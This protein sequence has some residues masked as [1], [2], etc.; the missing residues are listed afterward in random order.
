MNRDVTV[1]KYN[2]GMHSI[3]THVLSQLISLGQSYSVI[4][5]THLCGHVDRG[6]P[7]RCYIAYDNSECKEKC[8]SLDLCIA[9]SDGTSS[10]I[11]ITSTGSCPSDG[12]WNLIS[13]KT[14]THI[15][16]LTPNGIPGFNCN[17]KGIA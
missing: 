9:Y 5:S 6:P 15:G 2:L 8:T 17:V 4:S 16:D 3:Y 12:G 1:S 13:A 14:A 7:T 10:C 11:I